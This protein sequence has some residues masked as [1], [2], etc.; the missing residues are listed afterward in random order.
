MD[1]IDESGIFLQ[2]IK[3]VFTNKDYMFLFFCFSQIIGCF[4]TLATIVAE[5]GEEYNYQDSDASLFGAMF[6]FG[7]M[8]GSVIFGI[9]V[10]KTHLYKICICLICF[11]AG[12]FS[13]AQYFL[14]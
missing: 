10:E 2:S 11:L 8:V 5:M 13:L 3:L 9:I 14:F 12:I 6:I 7:G 4:N 1:R